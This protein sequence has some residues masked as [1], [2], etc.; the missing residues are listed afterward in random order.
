MLARVS[1]GKP[2]VDGVLGYEDSVLPALE[3]A[4]IAGHD[5]ILLGERGQ[6]KSRIIRSLVDLLDEWLPVVA[7][8]EINDDPYQPVSRVARDLVAE[9]GD[10]TPD[11]LGAP[12]R[13]LRREAGHARHLDGRPDRR[14]R[15]D[16]GGRGPLPLRRAHP[17]L[18]AR[19]PHEPGDLRHQRAPGPRRAH[20]GRPARRARGAGRPDPRPQGAPA[21]RHPARG[22]GQPGGL[23][24]PGTDHHPAQGPVRCTH[25]HPL[26]AGP[27]DRAHDR[28]PG[29]PGLRHPE[30][31]A[32]DPRVH[33]RDRRR[34]SASS[35]AAARG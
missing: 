18:R 17:A 28:R 10:D 31:P 9:A 23:H 19:S 24:E 35:P 32:R 12:Q 25:P 30:R 34:G 16:Q 3:H 8:S 22:L 7:G 14:G 2:V 5:V 11:H 15:P 20:P 13:T 6:A 29:G 4:L 26:P 1:E 21:A 27:R 33:V